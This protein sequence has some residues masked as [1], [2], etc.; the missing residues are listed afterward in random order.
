M[1]H[2]ALAIHDPKSNY[3]PYLVTT[4]TSVFTHT[5]CP[6]HVHLLHDETLSA[7]AQKAIDKLCT[8]YQHPL[9]FHTVALPDAIQQ[10]NFRQFSPASA[11]RLMLPQ[12]LKNEELVIYLDADL[13]FNQ[14]DIA[15]LVAHIQADPHQHP[16]A[17]VHD[18]L[19]SGSA[20]Q[21]AE[22]QSIGISANNYFNSGLLGMRPSRIKQNLLEELASFYMRHPQAVHLD[23]DLLN[24]LFQNQIHWLPEI[25][26]YQVNLSDAR[27]F[28]PLHNFENKVLHYSGKTKPLSGTFSPAD[29]YFWR[30]THEINQ[31]HQYI[32]TPIRYLQQIH[33]K[34]SAAR[35]I[36][37]NDRDATPPPPIQ[38]LVEPSS[39]EK[40]E[41]IAKDPRVK[42]CTATSWQ[43][44]QQAIRQGQA[45]ATVWSAADL[46]IDDFF[47]IARLH[48]GWQHRSR[49]VLRDA[50][51]KPLLVAQYGA[52][53][54]D[55][56]HILQHTP[57][58]L[59]LPW[60]VHGHTCTTPQPKPLLIVTATRETP[61]R[62]FTHTALGQSITHLR[63]HGVQIKVKASANNTQPIG[64]IYNQAI[65]PE[66][67]DHIIVFVHDDVRFDDIYLAHRLH[68]GLKHY[69]AIGVVGNNNPAPDQGEWFRIQPSKAGGSAND[70]LG[71]VLHDSRHNERAK[72]KIRFLSRF[73]KS[74]GPVQ[75][76]DGLFI[77]A[78]G[79]TLLKHHIQFDPDLGFHFYD[80]DFCRTAT[81]A[82]LKL[83]V[84]P[85]AMTHM[86]TGDFNNPSWKKAYQRYLNKWQHP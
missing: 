81:Q 78:Y 76:L 51:G 59:T 63:S 6:L 73:G 64:H 33:T 68:D 37:I 35:L 23:Q 13:I 32:K 27:C 84:W 45:S 44:A 2:I 48:E 10:L 9:S 25:Y 85:I 28:K 60:N 40:L 38:W 65:S 8:K 24:V 77:A 18:T 11:Y 43:S 1:T 49:C 26:N 22:L 39:E 20:N 17:A 34:P 5:S 83:G 71:S 42:L 57:D 55:L 7:Q 58:S 70:L 82:G 46:R 72:R 50:D 54:D 4:L 47:F 36:P 56:D 69:D 3:W 15:T 80:L 66:W 53:D 62:F 74:P 16:I 52:T 21:R 79:K 75:I 19:F 14:I 30:Y 29:I 67:A 31:I 41:L 12:I 61:E 86:S